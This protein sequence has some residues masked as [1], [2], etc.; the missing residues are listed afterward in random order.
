MAHSY[1]G[2]LTGLAG[3][4]L[5]EDFVENFVRILLPNF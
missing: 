5:G 3:R 2:R 1:N 4:L